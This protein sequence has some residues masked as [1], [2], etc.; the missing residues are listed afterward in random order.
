VTTPLATPATRAYLSSATSWADDA[1][2]YFGDNG[3]E[4]GLLRVAVAGG[5]IEAFW[6]ATRKIVA[7]VTLGCHVYWIAD[8]DFPHGLPPELVVAAE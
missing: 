7:G 5:P 8:A 3:T 1:Y 2:L 4:S 6:P